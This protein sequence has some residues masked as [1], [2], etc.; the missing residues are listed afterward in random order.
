M[1]LFVYDKLSRDTV[2]A[3]SCHDLSLSAFVVFIVQQYMKSIFIVVDEFLHSKFIIL[4]IFPSVNKQEFNIWIVLVFIHGQLHTGE[5]RFAGAAPGSPKIYNYYFTYQ[6]GQRN[7]FSLK[8]FKYKS[9]RRLIDHRF[10]Q[11]S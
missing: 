5:G 6:A 1:P 10:S 8:I 9:R 11:I 3:V 7:F 2:D 4:A